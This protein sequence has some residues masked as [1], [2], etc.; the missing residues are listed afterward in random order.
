MASRFFRALVLSAW[1][2]SLMLWLY[3]VARI[4]ISGADVHY[5][6]VDS[7]PSISISAMGVASFLLSFVS[8]AV[9]FTL[10]WKQP[11]TKGPP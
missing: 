9:Y 3:I 2:Y 5:P 8:M 7:I 11:W 4:L 1:L 6:F 10:W